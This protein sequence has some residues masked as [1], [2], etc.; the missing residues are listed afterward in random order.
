[1]ANHFILLD[2]RDMIL[3]IRTE[4]RMII[5]VSPVV[6]EILRQ[7]EVMPRLPVTSI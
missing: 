4:Q 2:D 1:M 5:R 7:L 6:K 3:R